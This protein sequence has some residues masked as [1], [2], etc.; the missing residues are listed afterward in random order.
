M[1]VDSYGPVSSM[2]QEELEEAEMSDEEDGLE[3]DD[4]DMEEDNL[5]KEEV[6]LTWRAEVLSHSM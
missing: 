4:E 2:G 5:V 1:V 6:R 3:G